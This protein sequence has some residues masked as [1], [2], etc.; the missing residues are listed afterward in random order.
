LLANNAYSGG[1][2][3]SALSGLYVDRL[4]GA[5]ARYSCTVNN[6]STPENAF[7]KSQNSFAVIAPDQV[8]TIEID[9]QSNGSS[10][11]NYAWGLF[12]CTFHFSNRPASYKVEI[13]TSDLVWRVVRDVL[14]VNSTIEIFLDTNTANQSILRLRFTI[15]ASPTTPASISSLEFFP[16]RPRDTELQQFVPLYSPTKLEVFAPSIAVRGTTAGGK[17]SSV[18]SGFLLPA[19]HTVSQLQVGIG[20]AGGAI[21]YCTDESGGAVPVFFDGTNWR[22]MT[23]RAIIS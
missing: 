2:R 12:V 21:A 9:L 23:D 17:Q 11:I 16:K 15:A 19:S 5:T 1:D 22:R 3:L 18:F 13:Q 4:F 14:A 20:Q 6:V 8:G 10:F 7:N